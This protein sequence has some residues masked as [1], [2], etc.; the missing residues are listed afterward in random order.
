MPKQRLLTKEKRLNHDFGKLRSQNVENVRIRETIRLPRRSR[1]DE[2]SYR[3]GELSA[4][5][6]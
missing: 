4:L 3:A 1:H 2:A 6:F 5:L